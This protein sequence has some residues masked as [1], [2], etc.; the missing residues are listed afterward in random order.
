MS[1]KQI[2]EE[3]EKLPLGEKLKLMEIMTKRILLEKKGSKGMS[4][5]AKLL[6]NDYETDPELISFTVLDKEAFYEAR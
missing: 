4:E 2:V 5:G 3:M 6:L 1:T